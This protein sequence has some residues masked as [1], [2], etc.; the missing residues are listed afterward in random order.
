MARPKVDN[1]VP[2][3]ILQAKAEEVW[4]ESGGQW[5]TSPGVPLEDYDE[6]C[7]RRGVKD[8]SEVTRHRGSAISP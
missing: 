4:K 5:G 2:C 7:R 8:V 1:P 3:D 6:M